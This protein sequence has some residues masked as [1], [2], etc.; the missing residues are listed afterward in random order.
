MASTKNELSMFLGS[1]RRTPG[2][3]IFVDTRQPGWSDT[4]DETRMRAHREACGRLGRQLRDACQRDN[5]LTAPLISTIDERRQQALND[6]K[7]RVG[8]LGSDE[9]AQ[10]EQILPET[11]PKLYNT[12]DDESQDGCVILVPYGI[13]ASGGFAAD[14]TAPNLVWQEIGWVQGIKKESLLRR[15]LLGEAGQAMRVAR[16]DPKGEKEKMFEDA[17]RLSIDIPKAIRADKLANHIIKGQRDKGKL[18]PLPRN[19]S[20]EYEDTTANRPAVVLRQQL[21]EKTE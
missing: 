12:Q 1:I 8:R 7:A 16:G 18:P 2:K 11:L 14:A 9:V 3:G 17:D 4:L 20:S 5:I 15:G 21:K 13:R 19:A 10:K 6:Q